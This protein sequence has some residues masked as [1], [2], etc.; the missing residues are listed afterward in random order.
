MVRL[1]HQVPAVAV[2]CTQTQA[3]SP[4]CDWYWHHEYRA[5][6]SSDEALS[7]AA[8]V[9][10]VYDYESGATF[11]ENHERIFHERWWKATEGRYTYELHVQPNGSDEEVW[12]SWTFTYGSFVLNTKFVLILT[13]VGGL[14]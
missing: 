5:L 6:R 13:D 11:K 3:G 8:Q 12:D 9:V 10:F 7:W 14:A 2:K 1:R 4:A